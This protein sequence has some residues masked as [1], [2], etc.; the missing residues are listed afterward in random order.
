MRALHGRSF[1]W[2]SFFTVFLLQAVILWFVSWPIQVASWAAAASPF[3]RLDALGAMVWLVGFLFEAIGDWQLAR[4]KANPKNAGRVMDRGLWRFTRHPN[5]FGDC[6]VWWGLYLIAAAGGAW[7][8]MLS[9]L[10][11]SVLLLKVSGV[12]LLEKTIVDRRPDYA[13]YQART[14]AFLPGP[15]RKRGSLLAAVTS[16]TPRGNGTHATP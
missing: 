4:F 12:S 11:M 6:C 9:P 13:D 14:N 10:V 3:G 5:Y 7:W 15:P 2:V 8:T 16:V 1:W